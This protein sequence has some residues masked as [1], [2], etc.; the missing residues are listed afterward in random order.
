MDL[1]RKNFQLTQC[2]HLLQA[3]SSSTKTP[4]V[5]N[6]MEQRGMLSSSWLLNIERLVIPKQQRKKTLIMVKKAIWK[7]YDGFTTSRTR[8]RW[9]LGDE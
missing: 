4:D 6:Q 5:F 8:R 9:K 2:L 3:F 1:S 7:F